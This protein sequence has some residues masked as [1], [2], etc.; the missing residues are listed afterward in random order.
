MGSQ[1]TERRPRT[2][3]PAR[4]TGGRGTPRWVLA[5]GFLIVL[6]VI[7][8]LAFPQLTGRGGGTPWVLRA[9]DFHALAFSPKDPNVVFFGHHNGLMRSEDGGRTW[10]PVVD[11]RNFDA[12]GLA[13]SHADPNQMYLA[14]HDIFQASQDGGASW[15]PIQHNLP[16]TDI[17]GFAMSPEDANRLY[18]FVVGHGVFTSA[19]GGR[20]WQKLPGQTPRD[21]M[22]LAA[23]GGNP[24]TLFTGGMQSGVT[25]S[26]DGGQTWTPAV[27][28]LGSR[29]VFALAADPTA[30][31][32]IYAGVEGGLYKSTDGGGTW[33]KLPFPGKNPVTVAVSPSQ[34]TT[35]VA[36]EFVQS[37]EG[38][39]YRSEDGGVSWS[40]NS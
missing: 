30:R 38:R 33:S 32:T 31:Q 6:A 23:A 16:G 15:Q 7:G 19:D 28:G 9:G 22:A 21:I 27:N 8:V 40:G 36:I 11:R 17:H 25:R 1:T 34:P 35:L 2:T 12:M 20:A 3:R 10:Q 5:L 37:G 14:G 13:V 29:N 24:E 4:R 39:V 26:T 18:A